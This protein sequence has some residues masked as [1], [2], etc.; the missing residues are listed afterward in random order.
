MLDEFIELNRKPRNVA[1]LTVALQAT[2]NNVSDE[3]FLKSVLN[4]RKRLTARVKT[5]DGEHFERLID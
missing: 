4:F 1:G 2:G 3:T 5:Q